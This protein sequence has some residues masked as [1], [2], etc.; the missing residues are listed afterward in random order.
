MGVQSLN[1]TPCLTVKFSVL[2]PLLH[3]QLVASLGVDL[4][5][6][7]VSTNAMA[8][9]TWP[10]V[11]PSPRLPGLNGLK[12]QFHC[13]PCSLEIVSVP[14]GPLPVL[15]PAAPDDPEGEEE[16]QAASAAASSAAAPVMSKRLIRVP[17]LGF[18]S[19]VSL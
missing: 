17:P 1:L 16:L 7:S 19:D 3:A 4:A 12:L 6:S 18:A 13:V 10:M 14:L 5:F 8:S 2:F 11:T 9:S 15:P